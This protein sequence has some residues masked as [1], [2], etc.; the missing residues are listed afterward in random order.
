MQWSIEVASAL[1]Y[2]HQNG[3]IHR[4]IKSDNVIFNDKYAAKLY[5]SPQ[6]ATLANDP[7]GEGGTPRWMAPECFEDAPTDAAGLKATDIFSYGRLLY[8]LWELKVPFDNLND[9]QAM[10]AMF[11]GKHPPVSKRSPK[12]I[13]EL[14]YKCCEMEP[15]KRLNISTVLLSLQQMPSTPP[16][17]GPRIIAID[18]I[19]MESLI[20]EGGFGAVYKG[21]WK[22]EKKIV[23]VKVGRCSERE[24]RIISSV[25]HTRI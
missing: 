8:E 17:E 7:Q 23:A 11:E 15:Q 25:E 19:V 13:A 6:I 21:K 20:A 4:D 5:I 2:L 3:I 14:T 18:D 10:R 1:E 22:S 24:I 16:G 12:F 9:L